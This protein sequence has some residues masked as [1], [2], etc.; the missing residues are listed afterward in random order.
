MSKPKVQINVKCQSSK[1]KFFDIWILLFELFCYLAFGFCH[2]T[3][4]YFCLLLLIPGYSYAESPVTTIKADFLEY[5]GNVYTAEGNVIITQG[6]RQLKASSVTL[7]NNTGDVRAYD[8]VEFTDGDNF[9]SSDRLLINIST[10][11]ARISQGKMF[12]K[13]ENYHIEGDDIERLSDERYRIKRAAFTT[14]DGDQPC[15]KFKGRNINI[16]MNHIFTAQNVFFTLWNLPVLYL[17]YIALPIIQ[18]RQTG[19]LI[20]R[21]GYNTGEGVKINNAFFWAISESQD[22]TIYADYYGAKGWGSGLEYR[23]VFSDDTGGQFNGYYINDTQL[24]RDRW[25]VKYNHKQLISDD[26]SAKLRIN[27]LNDETLYKDISEDIGE[28]L[29][30]TQDSDLYVNRR[31]DALSMHLWAQYTQNLIGESEGIFQRLPEAGL[32]VMDSRM[33]ALP[34]YWNLASS[35]SRWE[36]V[37]TTLT[38]LHFAPEISARLSGKGIVF[39]PKLSTEQTFYYIDGDT[40]PVHSDLYRIAATLSTKFY[41]SFTAGQGYILHFAEP[42]MAYEYAEGK[43]ADVPDV[44]L[45]LYADRLFPPFNKGG[46]RVDYLKDKNIISFSLINR[47]VSIQD[48]R[49][50]EPLYLRLTYNMN[51]DDSQSPDERLSDLRV[52]AIVR[53]FDTVS[54]DTDTVYSHKDK[55]IVS[56][57][58][59]LKFRRDN[60]HLTIGQRYSTKTPSIEF[61]TASAGIRLHEIDTSVGLWYDNRDHRMRETNYTVKYGSQCWGVTFSY[62]YRPEEAQFSVLLTLRGVGSVGRI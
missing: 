47:I 22:A 10:S 51:P 26:L 30:R 53:L 15:W 19:L 44:P 39:I 3:F 28:R 31:S 7:D 20:P 52:E 16:H 5:T 24:E 17:P 42:S 2:L 23:Y 32:R 34:I 6:N 14:C 61:L 54:I 40:N 8:N 9:L 12:I 58:T 48:D 25:N 35:A 11:Y 36:E 59:D 56:A 27:Y 37:N 60:G 46:T 55:A 57:G 49:R 50:Y 45:L 62:R 41:R 21:V 43:V 1:F 29:Q 13:G 33:G 18:E 38:R 4:V